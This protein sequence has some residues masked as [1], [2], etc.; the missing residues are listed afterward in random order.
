MSEALA[1]LEEVAFEH[2]RA[3][4]VWTDSRFGFI[5]GLSSTAIGSIGESYV[6][7]LCGETGLWC[8]FPEGRDGKRGREAW[9]IRIEGRTF[10]IK[11][12][13]QDVRGRFQFNNIRVDRQYDALL[14]IAIA[15]DDVRLQ[16]WTSD[17][18]YRGRDAPLVPMSRDAIESRKLTKGWAGL[19][20]IDRFGEVVRGVLRE[21]DRGAA[22]DLGAGQAPRSPGMSL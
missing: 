12:A 10:E 14:V 5:K 4:N 2:V 3:K 11:T 17:H 15:P 9:D 6:H 16:A 21:L 1:I 18:V 19:L 7:R 22:T 8:A 20:P 13:T